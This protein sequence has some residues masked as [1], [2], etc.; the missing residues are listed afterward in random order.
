[1]AA[2]QQVDVQVGHSLASIRAIV[3]HEAEAGFMNPFRTGHIS[4][5]QQQMAENG[6]ILRL[7]KSNAG[8]RLARHDQNVDRC[9][10]GNITEGHAKIILMD[11]GGGD[12]LITDFLEQ[13]LLS[14]ALEDCHDREIVAS[15]RPWNWQK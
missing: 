5:D 15:S 10:G 3:D 14:H 4:C 1:M 2:T 6:C 11:D 12:L 9:L 8:D 7:G 13:R